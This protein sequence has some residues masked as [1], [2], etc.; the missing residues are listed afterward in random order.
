MQQRGSGSGSREGLLVAALGLVLAAGAGALA[1]S[2]GSGSP[3]IACRVNADCASGVCQSDLTCAPVADGSTAGNPDGHDGG[4]DA[5]PIDGGDGALD[6]GWR[7]DG[8]SPGSDGGS[9]SCVPD[10]DGRIDA[11][12]VTLR[13]GLAATFRIADAVAF[14][15]QGTGG[16]WDMSGS[17]TGDHDALVELE[18]VSDQ[19]FGADFPD[20]TYAA[21]LADGQDLLGIFKVTSDELQLIGVASRSSGA[22]KTELTYAT[23]I[24]VLKFPLQLGAQWSTTSTVSGTAEGVPAYYTETYAS[25]VD[26]AGT[27][28]TPFADF[29]VLRVNTGLTRT[30]GFDVM[31]Q[32]TQSFVTDCF[33]TVAAVSSD[34]NADVTASEFTTAGELRRLAP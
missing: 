11:S 23:P 10:D 4:S 24:T 31:H 19:W 6:G 9:V 28:K 33:G 22:T 27:L 17:F 14:D 3:S 21:Q 5:G 20:A 2:C 30:V 18:T 32:R 34:L 15:T 26:K 7:S 12:E 16:V 29:P 8:G 25:E 13:P 1:A